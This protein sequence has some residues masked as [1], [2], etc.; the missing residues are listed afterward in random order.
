LLLKY[1]ETVAIFS[2]FFSTFSPENT[3]FRQKFVER[4]IVGVNKRKI[5]HKIALLKNDY[6][7]CICRFKMKISGNI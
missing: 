1:N 6:I 4:D 2:D 5:H 3:P 7:F